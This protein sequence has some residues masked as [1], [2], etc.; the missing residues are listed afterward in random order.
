MLADPI[1]HSPRLIDGD[2][3]ARLADA[4]QRRSAMMSLWP[5]RESSLLGT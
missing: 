5:I 1:G 3:A 2:V 4:V